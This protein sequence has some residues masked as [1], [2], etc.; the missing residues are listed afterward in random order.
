MNGPTHVFLSM[1]LSDV[2]IRD[3]APA[4]NA[5]IARI[6]RTSLEEFGA[7]HP[8]TVYYDKETDHLYEL[9]QSTP[10][11]WY[12]IATHNEQLLGGAGIF[13]TK[14]LPEGTCE[15]VKMY[16]HANAR[17][18][19]LGQRLLHTCFAKAKELGY[20]HMYL[21]TMPELNR[22]IPM[23]EKNGFHYLDGPMGQTGHFGCAIQ[24]MKAL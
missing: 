21:E 15:L 22:A 14:G 17:G 7:N 23:Y 9:F 1:Q 13:P 2:I 24:M 18:L 16:L 4:D 20:T 12:F 11:S 5:A 3:I 19:G 10:G 6:I 8:G